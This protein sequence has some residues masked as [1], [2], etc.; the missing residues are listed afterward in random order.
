MI[1]FSLT[2]STDATSSVGVHNVRFFGW[3][4]YKIKIC[5][6]ITN[7]VAPMKKNNLPF[8]DLKKKLKTNELL[9]LFDILFYK[10]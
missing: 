10:V 5:L 8:A 1:S 3:I 2:I 4:Y 6:I 7:K 9:F